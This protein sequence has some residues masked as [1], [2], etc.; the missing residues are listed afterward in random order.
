MASTTF[1]LLLFI[2]PRLPVN[3]RAGGTDLSFLASVPPDFHDEENPLS[4]SIYHDCFFDT[5]GE[6]A[7]CRRWGFSSICSVTCPS[8]PAPGT[9]TPRLQ[10][11]AL[12][13]VCPLLTWNCLLLT[14]PSAILPRILDSNLSFPHF[15]RSFRFALA[16][17]V[18][19]CLGNYLMIG[20]QQDCSYSSRPNVQAPLTTGVGQSIF[21]LLLVLL[22]ELRK[23]N[24]LESIPPSCLLSSVSSECMHS[25]S[26]RLIITRQYTCQRR[27]ELGTS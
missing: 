12:S 15:G 10:T 11:F 17:S 9:G 2:L 23:R 16:P 25:L 20:S 27:S 14:R 24:E 4:F 8:A 3:A 18:K 26:M 5:E 6:M 13:G 22:I 7:V 19:A 1:T 21:S